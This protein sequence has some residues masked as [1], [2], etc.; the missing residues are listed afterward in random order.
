M[1]RAKAGSAENML[2]FLE[3][4]EPVRAALTAGRPVVALESTVIAHGLPW[5]TNVEVAE[6]MEEAVRREGATPATIA[7]LDGRIVVGLTAPE[8][9]R[10]ATAGQVLKASRR[11]LAPALVHKSLAATTVAGTLACAAL[12]GIDVFATGGIGGVHRGAELS[13]DISADL[14]ELSRL[15]VVTVSAG[16][17]AI[18]DLPLT[19]EYLETH[20]VPVIGYGTNELPAFFTRT[21]GLPVPHR[22]DTADEVAA[23]AW[24]EWRLGHSGGLLVTCPVPTEHA[25]APQL[26]ESA[27]VTALREADEQQVQGARLTPFL[28]KRVG[29]LTGGESVTANKALLLNNAGVSAKIACSL[30]K[31]GAAVP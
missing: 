1:V 14:V 27:I 28:L 22:A 13:F 26:A 12:A 23:I 29:E 21:S 15:P 11:D 2:E 9:E 25:L 20:S 3:I 17:K 30:A 19:L 18:L 4:R 7:L 8:I 6:A 10:L 5:P 24:T 16:A 31:L